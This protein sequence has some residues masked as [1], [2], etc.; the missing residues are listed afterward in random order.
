M[1]TGDPRSPSYT[2]PNGVTEQQRAD[3]G[4]TPVGASAPQPEGAEPGGDAGREDRPLLP[5]CDGAAL[6]PRRG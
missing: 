5:P 2:S 1:A 4:L 3:L 6:R